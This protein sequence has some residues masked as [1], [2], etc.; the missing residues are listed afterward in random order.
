MSDSDQQLRLH[1]EAIE[2]LEEEKKGISDDIKD[3]YSLLKG[4][5]FDPKVVKAIIRRRAMERA[6]VEEFDAVL[7]TYESSLGEA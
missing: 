5:G 2:T 7:Q 3:R 6:A 1:I 4:E